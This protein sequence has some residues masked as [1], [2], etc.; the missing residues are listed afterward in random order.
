MEE[1]RG[2]WF[3]WTVYPDGIDLWRCQDRV[4]RGIPVSRHDRRKPFSPTIHTLGKYRAGT[5]FSRTS[6][7]HPRSHARDVASAR[8]HF[9]R[10]SI[11]RL[12]ADQVG[13]DRWP[14]DHS[15]L[16]EYCHGPQ[17]SYPNSDITR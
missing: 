14:V 4:R 8:N 3:V 7:S 10:F 17:R 11:C 12:G 13:V 6:S 5:H 2:S 1:F 9:C 15:C 16:G